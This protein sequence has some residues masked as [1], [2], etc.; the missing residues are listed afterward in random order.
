MKKRE[1]ERLQRLRVALRDDEYMP[2]GDCELRIVCPRCEADIRAAV[3]RSVRALADAG[4]YRTVAKAFADPNAHRGTFRGKG[5]ET[6][7]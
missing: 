1:P 6:S 4:V 2:C 3:A 5:E 7:A